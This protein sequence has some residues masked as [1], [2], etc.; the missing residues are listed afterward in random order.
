MIDVT[1]G[2]L[3]THLHREPAV[4]NET[5]Q[6]RRVA[7][8]LA[9]NAVNVLEAVVGTQSRECREVDAC[10]L[11]C[12]LAQLTFEPRGV[13]FIRTHRQSSIDIGIANLTVEQTA[14]IEAASSP[15]RTSHV[16]HLFLA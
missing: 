7:G 1:S 8:A 3:V 6:A 10:S 11:L 14:Q 9:A 5:L 12:E 4:R 2:A 16:S 13:A 15:P